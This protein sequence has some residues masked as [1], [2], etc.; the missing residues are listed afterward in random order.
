MPKAFGSNFVQNFSV[1]GR[2]L[3]Y[4]YPA[5]DGIKKQDEVSFNF[6]L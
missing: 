3:T 4:P 6:F 5:T 2:L 1:P